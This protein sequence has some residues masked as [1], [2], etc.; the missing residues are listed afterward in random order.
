MRLLLCF[1]TI[2]KKLTGGVQMKLVILTVVSFF[3]IITF[4]KG[5]ESTAH[6][7]V[8]VEEP[9]LVPYSRFEVEIIKPYMSEGTELISYKLPELLVGVKGGQQVNLTRIPESLNSWKSDEITAHCTDIN[10]FFSCNIHV[11][12]AL[13]GEQNSPNLLLKQK[14]LDHLKSLQNISEIE[15]SALTAVI[16]KFHT[17]DPA[18]ILS[19]EL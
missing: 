1:I 2:F 16:D 17:G 6:Y 4:A 8:P 18:G 9:E 15:K 7:V 12:K 11:N 14:A 10:E 19:Y 13:N 3:A 5:P